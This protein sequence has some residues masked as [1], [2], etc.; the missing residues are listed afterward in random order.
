MNVRKWLPALVIVIGLFI[1]FVSGLVENS[2]DSAGP[3]DKYY[4]FPLAWRMV[5]T[6]TGEKY[7]YAPE[8]LIDCIFGIVI[9]SIIAATALLTEKWMAKKNTQIV[10]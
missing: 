10:K 6:T 5:D 4:G 9:V 3:S 8:L 2:P 1:G 7:T